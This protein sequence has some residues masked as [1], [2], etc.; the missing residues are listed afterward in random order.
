MASI[1]DGAIYLCPERV[2]T[3]L[4]GGMEPSR[5]EEREGREG[6]EGGVKEEGRR[7]EGGGK[8]EGGREGGREGRR[9]YLRCSI[10]T[11]VCWKPVFFVPVCQCTHCSQCMQQWLRS[12]GN[13]RTC[14]LCREGLAGVKPTANLLM[15]ATYLC[16]GS[17]DDWGHPPHSRKG[18]S[19]MEP[20]SNPL[21]PPNAVDHIGSKGRAECGQLYLP[22][23]WSRSPLSQK[24]SICPML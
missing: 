12:Q 10:C 7:R 22:S 13:T 17:G 14:P 6:R 15:R 3:H 4:S 18:P 20:W 1:G 19:G 11:E 5:R 9:E 24:R 2:A 21:E 16:T 23:E 8:D